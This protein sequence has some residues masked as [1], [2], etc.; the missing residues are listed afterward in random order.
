MS[1]SKF[2]R[3]FKI[4]ILSGIV[5][6]LCPLS[7]QS[8]TGPTPLK[9]DVITNFDKDGDGAVSRSE[10]PGP[11][12]FFNRMDSN[13]DGSI[14]RE[15]LRSGRPSE[16][17]KFSGQRGSENKFDLS[18]D[19]D[20]EPVRVDVPADVKVVYQPKEN[21]VKKDRSI[22]GDHPFSFWSYMIQN[23]ID[24]V[25]K[26]AA[27]LADLGAVSFKSNVACIWGFVEPEKGKFNW[28][29]SDEYVVQAKTY[30][31]KPVFTI[32]P[33]RLMA[34]AGYHENPGELPKTPEDLAG[35]KR[36]VNMTAERYKETVKVWQVVN[37]LSMHWKDSAEN[38]AK[39][40]KI[41]VDELRNVQP[42]AKIVLAAPSPAL[43]GFDKRE[44]F[45]ED[46]FKALQQY[47]GRYFDYM[48]IHFIGQGNPYDPAHREMGK[49]LKH[50]RQLAKKYGYDDVGFFMEVT[51]Y[52]GG[53]PQGDLPYASETDQAIGMLRRYITGAALGFDQIHHNGGVVER[54]FSK[55]GGPGGKQKGRTLDSLLWTPGVHHVNELVPKLSYFSVKKLIEKLRGFDNNKTEIIENGEN[56]IF[57]YKFVIS[58]QP[59]YVAFY[60]AKIDLADS[61]TVILNGFNRAKVTK[62][63]PET[64][65]GV[66]IQD[67]RSAFQAR[68][69]KGSKNALK[70]Q[71]ADGIPV[72]IE[73]DR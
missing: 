20:L 24:Y 6:A 14:T 36:Y 65:A 51:T 46:I 15:E 17:R 16:G 10:F 60:E 73:T 27:Y 1:V 59:I 62:A 19:A 63:V 39:L 37:E 44:N 38:Y 42:E 2:H 3:H 22:L 8:Q 55:I 9:G 56:Y 45:V 32:E 58:E 66:D 12:R 31:F 29:L 47:P 25:G 30:G 71:L 57:L 68:E 48:D 72:F 49:W 34:G 52:G 26:E 40:L 33:H 4:L 28:R 70:I 11:E 18:S 53:D 64:K 5:L 23:N 13:S 69:V 54:K 43:F 7:G 67:H 35:Y 21:N 41:T 61:K 50:Y